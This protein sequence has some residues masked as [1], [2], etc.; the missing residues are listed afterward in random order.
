[1]KKGI[2]FLMGVLSGFMLLASSVQLASAVSLNVATPVR[3]VP[4]CV[5]YDAGRNTLVGLL[6][7]TAGTVHWVFCDANGTPLKRGSFNMAANEMHPF[8][9][10]TEGGASLAGTIGYLTFA[11]DVAPTD[12]VLNTIDNNA[13]LSANVFYV[14]VNT[15]D[16]IFLP[17][18]EATV[19]DLT[20]TN[21]LNTF[22][23]GNLSW[24]SSG[25][26][27]VLPDYLHLR[28]FIDGAS[29]GNDTQI[30][31]FSTQDL[32]PTQSIDVRDNNGTSAPPIVIS[33]PSKRLNVINPEI[34]AGWPTGY[35]DGSVR[36]KVPA[37]TA[38][39]GFSLVSS[40]SLGAVQT[41]VGAK[42]T[43]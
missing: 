27:A 41:L 39:Y 38:A 21:N 26:G 3:V 10:A 1:M 33:T 35:L 17:T 13:R 29:G 7:Q 11:M 23:L 19:S 20:N 4:Y 24:S 30:V 28:Y 40:T 36:W 2:V 18:I 43:L 32:A 6:S 34:T 37:G 9:W 42:S 31:I 16:A 8:S 22:L 14:D 12:N 25:Y 5:F 15:H